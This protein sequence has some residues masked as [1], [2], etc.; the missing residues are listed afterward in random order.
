MIYMNLFIQIF[1]NA[2]EKLLK[3]VIVSNQIWAPA[4]R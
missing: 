3:A 1:M 2:Q 4:K